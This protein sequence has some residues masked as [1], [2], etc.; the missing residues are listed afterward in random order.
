MST[1]VSNTGIFRAEKFNFKISPDL[2]QNAEIKPQ[3]SVEK[4][5]IAYVKNANNLALPEPTHHRSQS[6]K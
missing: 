3:K 6:T 1:N 5:Y 4:S 2:S